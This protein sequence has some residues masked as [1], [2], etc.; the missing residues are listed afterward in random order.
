MKEY[1]VVAY[2]IANNKRRNKVCDILSKYGKR[3]NKSV[4]EC[5]ITKKDFDEIK[6]GISEY[7]KKGKDIVLYY[8]LCK[9][10]IGKI[11]R[12]GIVSEKKKV[13]EVV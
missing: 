7:I 10:C 3:V 5:F 6:K 1:I 4:F 11:E 8:H 12:D 13:V 9:D 2:D